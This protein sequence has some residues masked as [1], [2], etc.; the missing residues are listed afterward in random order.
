LWHG[1]GLDNLQ[2]YDW[3]YNAAVCHVDYEDG[4]YNV[5]EYG[6]DAH[7]GELIT[8]VGVKKTD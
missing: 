4:K 5:I 3:V 6:H 2:Q 8:H 7:L 1:D